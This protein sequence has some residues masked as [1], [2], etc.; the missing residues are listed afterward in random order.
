MDL[1]E[2]GMKDFCDVLKENIYIE[3]LNLGNNFI[4][5]ATREVAK[6]IHK[7]ESI[8][9]LNL[10]NNNIQV[11]DAVLFFEYIEENDTIKKLD[12]SCKKKRKRKKFFF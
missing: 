8:T 7:T 12:L 4:G 10:S 11:E 5:S 2:Y 3:T 9:D 1:T 6:L